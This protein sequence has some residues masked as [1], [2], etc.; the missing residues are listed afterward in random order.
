MNWS[1]V[2]GASLACCFFLII[3]RILQAAFSVPCEEH[4]VLPELSCCLAAV[5]VEIFLRKGNI[6]DWKFGEESEQV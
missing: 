5:Q 4:V 6:S 3:F 2:V 1:L